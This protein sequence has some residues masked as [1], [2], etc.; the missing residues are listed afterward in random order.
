ML[1]KIK[2]ANHCYIAFNFIYFESTIPVE[3]HSKEFVKQGLNFLQKFETY[4]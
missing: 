3:L 1:I 2:I 4:F